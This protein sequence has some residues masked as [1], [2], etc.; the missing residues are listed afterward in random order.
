M[1][2]EERVDG[3]ATSEQVD[4][5]TT[6]T[7]IGAEVLAQ[8]EWGPVGNFG[9]LNKFGVHSRGPNGVRFFI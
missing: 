4:G 8:P 1:V 5:C 7:G 6:Q 3:A 9:A 2:V